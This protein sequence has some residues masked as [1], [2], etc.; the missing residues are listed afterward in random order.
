MSAQFFKIFL[1]VLAV[2]LTVLS[3]IWIGFSA[4]FPRPPARFTYEGARPAEDAGAGQEDV[5]PTDRS[6]DQFTVDHMGTARFNQWIEL[7]VPTKPF[8][9]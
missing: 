8:S 2:H 9:N 4:P 7:R 6:S 3:I 5:W 1:G